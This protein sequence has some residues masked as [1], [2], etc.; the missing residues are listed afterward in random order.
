[1]VTLIKYLKSV[2]SKELNCLDCYRKMEVRT[3]TYPTHCTTEEI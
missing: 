1:M 3:V 2:N